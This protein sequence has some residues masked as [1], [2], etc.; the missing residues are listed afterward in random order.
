MFET[1][2]S[3][4]LAA[5]RGH[6]AVGHFNIHNLEFAKA[7]L[8][9]AQEMKSPVILGANEQQIAYMGGPAAVVGMVGGL[10]AALPVTV[11]VVLHLDHGTFEG[12]KTCAN[13]GFSSVMFDG[14]HIPF[15]ENIEKTRELAELCREKGISFEAEVGGIGGTVNGVTSAGEL[16]DP[17]QCEQIANLGITML[18]CGF[19]NI[20]GV[21]PPDWKGLDFDLLA[22]INRRVGEMPLVLHGGS[23][24]PETMIREAIRRGV[25]KINVSTELKLAYAKELRA[26]FEAGRDLDMK[27]RGF[28]PLRIEAAGIVGVKE[29]VRKKI[30]LFGAEGKAE[31]Y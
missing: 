26:Y 1:A 29:I 27:N 5:K 25:A 14:S 15:A 3:M 13:A 31:S 6:Y 2:G 23:G 20:H 10:I 28:D 19:G 24:I 8:E 18:A 16:A 30:A 17:A 22:E 9:T 7:V 12:A 11:P 21:Y 4:L